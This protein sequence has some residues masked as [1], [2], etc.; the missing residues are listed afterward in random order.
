MSE[1][2]R[3][4]LPLLEAGQAQKHVTMNGGLLRLDALS[5][6]A[7]ISAGL[8][9]PPAAPADGDGYLVAA[10][11]SGVW[12]G[13]E[14]ELA[15]FFGGEWTFV[16]PVVGWRVWIEDE[17]APAVWNGA[18]W[19]RGLTG[20][21]RLGAGLAAATIVGDETIVAGSGFDAALLIPDRSV[22][23]GVSGRVTTAISGAGVT[24]WRVGV[25]ESTNRYGSSIGLA[26]NSS[27]NGVTDAPVGYYGDTALRIEP[28]GG[29]FGGGAVRLAIHYLALT[30]PDPV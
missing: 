27:F 26:Q 17:A 14:G 11:A 15:S 1:T 13:R 2:P 30:P 8:A 12:T 18:V 3:N 16:P 19:A 6:A 4:A 24:G 29:D 7:V 20:G 10:P 23:I 25:A 28:E 9:D 21:T 22:V 5:R